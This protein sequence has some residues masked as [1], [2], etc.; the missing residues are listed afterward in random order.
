MQCYVG[1]II[2]NVTS[3]GLEPPRGLNLGHTLV[4]SYKLP[5]PTSLRILPLRGCDSFVGRVACVHCCMCSKALVCMFVLMLCRLSLL[6]GGH[7]VDV[8]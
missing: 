8:V 4:G 2:S 3:W 7:P 5:P 1:S 6:V